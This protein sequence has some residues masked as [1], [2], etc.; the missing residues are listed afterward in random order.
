MQH[1]FSTLQNFASTNPHLIEIT[2]RERKQA[3]VDVCVQTHARSSEETDGVLLN[4]G[5]PPKR[6]KK[7]KRMQ[8][9]H[10]PLLLSKCL[11][12]LL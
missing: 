12:T 10:L 6:L 3:E 7:E 4:L 8:N 5:I 2:G 9:K 11:A 1:N